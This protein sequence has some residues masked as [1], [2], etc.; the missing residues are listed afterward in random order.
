ML[1]PRGSSVNKSCRS[2]LLKQSMK[3]VV[4]VQFNDSIFD[5]LP[6]GHCWLSAVKGKR[7]NVLAPRQLCQDGASQ[8]TGGSRHYDAMHSPRRARSVT[9]ESFRANKFPDRFDHV[10]E[11]RL[12]KAGV[13]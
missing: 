8:H 10:I 1:H 11:H 7:T 3:L 5:V 13:N 12:R 9:M 6:E 4:L 2:K